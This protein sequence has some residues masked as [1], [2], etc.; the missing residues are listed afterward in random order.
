[1]K[2]F[3]QG[4]SPYQIARQLRM[5]P[6]SVYTSLKAAKENFPKAQKM[7]IELESLGWPDKLAEVE[8]NIRS[9]SPHKRKVAVKHEEP[10][11]A[12]KMG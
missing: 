3:L 11:I 5:D 7:L 2:L 10:E 9:K 6:P 8:Q 12:F 1:M 4:K